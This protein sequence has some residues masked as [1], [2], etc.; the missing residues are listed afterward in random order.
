MSKKKLLIAGIGGIGGF[1]GGLLAKDYYDSNDVDIFF[2]ARGRNLLKIKES[3]LRINENDLEL[4]I[5]P[6]LVSDKVSDFGIVDYILMCTKTYDLEE[7]L[8]QLLPSINDNTIIIPLQ[9]GVDSHDKIAKQLPKNS[10]AKGCV[11][12][13]SRL[14]E[15]GL[16]IK[17]GNIHSLFFGMD[18]GGN[19]KLQWLQDAFL[20]ANIKSVV[21]EDINKITWEKFIFLASIATATAYFDS[22][23]GGILN[24]KE[25]YNMLINLINEVTDLAISKQINIDKNQQ[26]VVLEKLKSLPSDATT[27]MHSDFRNRKNKTELESLT[28]YVVAEG[29]Q[30]RINIET[31]NNMYKVLK[32]APNELYNT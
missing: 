17:N 26:K 15:P 11:Y 19:E 30:N 7:T 28:G 14:E 18:N 1:F 8:I 24:S 12:L 16:I 9:N 27:S 4:V 22:N 31:F 29:K 13:V 21:S 3:G 23:I 32:K 5:K 2:L 6:N 25:K 10:I 20:N